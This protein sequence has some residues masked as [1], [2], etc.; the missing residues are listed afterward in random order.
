MTSSRLTFWPSLTRNSDSTLPPA[1]VAGDHRRACRRVSVATWKSTARAAG[2]RPGRCWFGAAG[3]T[4]STRAAMTKSIATP[5]APHLNFCS[6]AIRTRFTILRQTAS[7]RSESR[8]RNHGALGNA[9]DRR[10][11]DRG[12]ELIVLVK[13]RIRDVYHVP[14]L[15]SELLGYKDRHRLEEVQPKTRCPGLRDCSGYPPSGRR[16]RR[17]CWPARR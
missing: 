17:S 12:Q 5:V 11:D 1:G 8:R 15:H 3:V 13:W 4:H 10:C 7:P 2:R 14:W 9:H 16:K 6:R